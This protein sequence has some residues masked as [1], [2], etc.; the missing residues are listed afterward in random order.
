MPGRFHHRRSK[1]RQQKA[2]PVI[3]ILNSASPAQ[4]L[5]YPATFRQG[6]SDTGYIEGENLA[7]EYRW[8]EGQYDR[9]PALAA[10]LVSRKVD[11]I[12]TLGGTVAA[13][14]AKSA[15]STIPII[16]TNV[17]SDPVEIGLVASLARAA[18]SRALPTSP[19]S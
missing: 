16:F 11:L 12:V 8:A 9:L 15:T 18:T 14:A 17:G 5:W 6:L 2:M 13:Q 4:P 19:S 10:D 7:I 1:R 3:G